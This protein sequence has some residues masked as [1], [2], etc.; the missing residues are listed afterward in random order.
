VSTNHDLYLD[1]CAALAAGSIEPAD[2]RLLEEHLDLGCAECLAFLRDLSGPIEALARSVPAAKP[3]RGLKAR[4]MVAIAQSKGRGPGSA[5]LPVA[6]DDLDV[7]RTLP[8]WAWIVIVALAMAAAF[9]WWRATRNEGREESVRDA[10]SESPDATRF[11]RFVATAPQARR[12][13]LDRQPDAPPNLEVEVVFDE[14]KRRAAV[15][16]VRGGPPAG[17]VLELWTLRQG[18]PYSEGLIPASGYAFIENTGAA[19]LLG[20]FAV[21][22]EPPQGAKD[23]ESP[24]NVALLKQL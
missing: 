14:G 21:S 2:R 7:G 15:R 1:L 9:G 20:G 18:K 12:L 8:T 17:K 13:S 16:V 11:G 4:V 5:G 23:R 3:S 19:P 6:P 22:V 24:S 10:P